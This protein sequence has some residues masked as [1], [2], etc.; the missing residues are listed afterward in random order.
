[1]KVKFVNPTNEGNERDVHA[2]CLQVKNQRVIFT[3]ASKL[4]Q[5]KA[6]NGSFPLKFMSSTSEL[7][8][9]TIQD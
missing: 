4:I 2:N 1:M 9:T 6:V 7:E 3:L 8:N 5:L